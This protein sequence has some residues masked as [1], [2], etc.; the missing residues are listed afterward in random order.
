MSIHALLSALLTTLAL[1]AGVGALGLLITL[2]LGTLIGT[3]RRVTTFAQ[4]FTAAAI[5]GTGGGLIFLIALGLAC[6]SG[7]CD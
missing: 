1:I 6:A 7:W 2:G 3:T 4:I 5:I